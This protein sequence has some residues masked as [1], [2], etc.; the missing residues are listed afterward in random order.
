M[1]PSKNVTGLVYAVAALLLSGPASCVAG[2]IFFSNLVQPG[3]QYGP[4]PL[5]IGHTPGYPVAGSGYTSGASRFTVDTTFRLTEIEAPLFYAGAGPNQIDVFLLS[6]V[7]GS[8]GSVIESFLVANL[9]TSGALTDITSVLNPVLQ[10]G[11]AYWVAATGGPQTFDAWSFTL[12][13]GNAHGST[14][15]AVGGSA[16]GTD[17]TLSGLTDSGWSVGQDS[18]S[19]ARRPALVIVGDAVPEPT[20]VL[21]MTGGL[22]ALLIRLG[23]RT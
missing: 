14:D 9:P 12:F 22:T 1:Y 20:A 16:N 4:D 7:L 10:S 17:L 21:L 13:Q 8:P 5:G 6:D 19:T 3:D 18:G 2:T 23:K 15:L 11:A